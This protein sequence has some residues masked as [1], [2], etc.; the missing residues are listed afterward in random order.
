VCFNLQLI[1]FNCQ[2]FL[3][4]TVSSSLSKASTNEE[5]NAMA[6]AS[7]PA[8]LARLEKLEKQNRRLCRVA[9]LALLLASLLAL[10]LVWAG[11]RIGRFANVEADT[12]QARHFVLRAGPSEDAHFTLYDHK[13]IQ[14]V[15]LRENYLG[16]MGE[17]QQD[18]LRITTNEDGGQILINGRDWERLADLRASR[19]S[20]GN[21]HANLYFGPRGTDSFAVQVDRLGSGLW[22]QQGKLRV[23]LFS[24]AGE[25]RLALQ[26]TEA[27]VQD[28][29]KLSVTPKGPRFILHDKFGNETFAKP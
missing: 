28:S 24:E 19:D 29:A 2:F 1:V 16:F 20:L 12:A 18:R 23:G 6:N 13:G 10:N 26:H 4:T 9:L 21:Y 8:V 22:L 25:A 15:L 7:E 11:L 27:P 3:L 5:E 17:D 14:R